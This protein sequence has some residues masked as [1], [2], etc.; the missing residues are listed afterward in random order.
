MSADNRKEGEQDKPKYPT[1][2]EFSGMS[3]DDKFKLWLG[4]PIPAQKLLVGISA[5]ASNVS[6]TMAQP[7]SGTSDEEFEEAKAVLSETPFFSQTE[8]GR[9]DVAQP[10]RDFINTDLRRIWEEQKRKER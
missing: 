9:L 1:L 7:V 8:T 6:P 3:P 4:L 10:M 2:E 5:F